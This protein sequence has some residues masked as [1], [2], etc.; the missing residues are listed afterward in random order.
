MGQVHSKGEPLL[1]R[2]GWEVY[3]H[4]FAFVLPAG[5]TPLFAKLTTD[6]PL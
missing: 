2:G 3:W 5:Q 1:R 6:K 4:H